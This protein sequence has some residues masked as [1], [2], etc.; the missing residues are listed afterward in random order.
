L[1]HRANR[2]RF[3]RGRVP[4]ALQGLA[5]HVL[6]PAV[7]QHRPAQAVVA[8]FLAVYPLVILDALVL[9]L[10]QFLQRPRLLL[11][12]VDAL[13]E[14]GQRPGLA[15][16]DQDEALFGV[17][18]AGRAGLVGQHQGIAQDVLAQ[19]RPVDAQVLAQLVL[20]GIQAGQL[21]GVAQCLA[22]GRGADLLDEGG[23]A[24][25]GGM[26]AQVLEQQAEGD[27]VG[28]QP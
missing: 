3:R 1:I 12:P 22:H 16:A 26:A 9:A 10:L 8:G 11:H 24:Q 13:D 28:H 25:G 21:L 14:V 17:L 23:V 5:Q 27:V 7:Q 19:S 18:L 2:S 20:D 15:G 6:L 4:L